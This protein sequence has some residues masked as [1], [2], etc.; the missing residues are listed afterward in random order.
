MKKRHHGSDSL[1]LLL[2][3]VC[4]MFGAILL[5]AILVALMAQT[6][7]QDSPGD[8]AGGEMLQRRV[9]VAEE[10]LA[11]ARRLIEQAAAA[12]APDSNPLLEEKRKLEEALAKARGERARAQREAESDP[13]NVVTDYS[14]E[15]EKLGK[16]L[17]P[18]ERKM[19][20]VNNEIRAYE[21]E[22]ARIEGRM[23]EISSMIQKE[24]GSRAVALRFPK[25][26]A[27]TKRPFNIICKFDRVYPLDLPS[28]G[29]NEVSIRWV[30]KEGDSRE[31]NPIEQAGWTTSADAARVESM[32]RGLS[33]SD[34]YI[35]LYV[36]PDSFEVFRAVREKATKMGLDCGFEL[37]RPGYPIVWGSSGNA[38]P[39]PL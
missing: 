31:S 11:N 14:A 6:G 34:H 21:Q 19:Q 9:A 29:R 7:K 28:G 10:D 30:A 8:Q 2:D 17:R 1:E 35:V 12:P 33:K 20:Q 36:Y 26:R 24:A 15:E 25:E 37:Q 18:L 4:S 13:K 32:L 39:P 5:I 3:T 16:Q 27:Q 22:L 38:P 23:K